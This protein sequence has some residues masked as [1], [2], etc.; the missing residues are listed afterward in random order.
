MI[1]HQQMKGKG[2]RKIIQKKE[3]IEAHSLQQKCSFIIRI[4]AEKN[5]SRGDE[6]EKPAV[7]PKDKIIMVV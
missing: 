6:K 1:F 2:I 7:F 3:Q 4:V 5:N